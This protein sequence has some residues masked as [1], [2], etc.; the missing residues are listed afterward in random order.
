MIDVL[1]SCY[2]A[3]AEDRGQLSIR[4]FTQPSRGSVQ[5]LR[6]MF[7]YNASTEGGEFTDS[8]TY[9]VKDPKGA[10]FNAATVFITA[11]E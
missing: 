4:E 7:Q 9:W 6:G 5:L 8:F 11:G 3:N 2:D 1:S 10:V